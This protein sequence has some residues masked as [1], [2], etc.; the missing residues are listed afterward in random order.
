M[1]APPQPR[2]APNLFDAVHSAAE[3]K[4]WPYRDAPSWFLVPA[5]ANS[6]EEEYEDAIQAIRQDAAIAEETRTNKSKGGTRDSIAQA[7][8]AVRRSE[9]PSYDEVAKGWPGRTPEIVSDSR[10]EKQGAFTGKLCRCDCTGCGVAKE[11]DEALHAVLQDCARAIRRGCELVPESQVECAAILMRHCCKVIYRKV[12]G[13][14]AQGLLHK[15]ILD[16][17]FKHDDAWIGGN[18]ST[19]RLAWEKGLHDASWYCWPCMA[20]QYQV[21][22]AE[23]LERFVGARSTLLTPKVTWMLKE[24]VARVAAGG[25]RSG[26]GSRS[27]RADAL[28]Q[29]LTEC[30]EDADLPTA[31]QIIYARAKQH[32]AR[33]QKIGV[34]DRLDLIE[35]GILRPSEE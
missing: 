24:A 17:G 6:V 2:R 30:Q 5:V 26:Y 15:A 34:K 16:G 19:K 33:L 8:G 3:C 11:G 10:F 12:V 1:Q 9:P 18:N 20:E 22:L 7:I 28:E 14:D 13:C 25:S 23:I 29:R 35:M 32:G 4:D 21:S 27:S 31:E